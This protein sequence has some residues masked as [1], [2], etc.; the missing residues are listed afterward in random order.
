VFEWVSQGIHTFTSSPALA[1]T[2]TANL[3]SKRRTFIMEN[4]PYQNPKWRIKGPNKSCRQD[5][6]VRGQ[7]VHT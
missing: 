1:C 7:A 4:C 2:L 5:S 3:T 6:S